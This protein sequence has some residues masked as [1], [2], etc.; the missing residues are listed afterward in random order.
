LQDSLLKGIL[1]IAGGD[2]MNPYSQKKCVM[3]VAGEASGDLHGAKLVRAMLTQDPSL[4]FVGI[5]GSELRSAGVRIL[6]DAAELAVVGITEVLSKG[7]SLLKSVSSATRL[8]KTLVPELLILIDFPDFNL[9]LAAKAR[10]LGIPVLY[11]ISPQVWA[12]RRGRIE[13][14]KKCVDHMAVILPFEETFYREHDVPVTFVGHPLLDGRKAPGDKKEPNTVTEEPVI[15]L[16]P[17]SRDKEV[18]RHL[19]IMLA[20]AGLLSRRYETIRFVLSQ[21]STVAPSLFENIVKKHEMRGRLTVTTEHVGEIF[22]KSHLVVAVSGTVTLEAALSGTPAVII[23]R[24]SPFSYWV[25]RMLVQVEHIGL[26]NLIAGKRIVPELI[27]KE[28]TPENIAGHV[29]AMLNVP[30]A[31]KETAAELLLVQARLGHPGASER[32]ADIAFNLMN[33]RAAN[34]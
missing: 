19:P 30:E 3:I 7:L 32:V 2:A 31:L 16:L 11:Y 20:A 17:G 34:S 8:L 33:S 29:L 1:K 10:K 26:V 24:V 6:V 15:G 22:R 28:V 13:K 14:I 4:F 5:G 25:G 12:W 21:A 27:Q 9:H 18:S 23:Y